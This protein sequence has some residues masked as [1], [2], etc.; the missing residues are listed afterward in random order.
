MYDK[1]L[2]P[3]WSELGTYLVDG[4]VIKDEFGHIL[5]VVT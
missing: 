5:D 1:R 3:V 4:Y 2:A